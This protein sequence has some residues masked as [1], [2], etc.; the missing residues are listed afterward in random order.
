MYPNDGWIQKLQDMSRIYSKELHKNN[1]I[2]KIKKN[3][4]RKE[5]R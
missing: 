3:T 4:I 1:Y 2:K 5:N